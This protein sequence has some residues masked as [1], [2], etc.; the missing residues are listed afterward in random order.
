MPSQ[1]L[2]LQA[3]TSKE[4]VR[5]GYHASRQESMKNG[6][7]DMDKRADGSKNTV[8]RWTPERKEGGGRRVITG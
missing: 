3:G 8:E 6:R 4:A 5:W 7:D 1:Q 2:N